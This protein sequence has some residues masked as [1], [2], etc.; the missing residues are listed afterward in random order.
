[1]SIAELF[2]AVQETGWA[3]A[4]RESNVVYPVILS[5]HLLAIA[6]FGGA[7]LLTNLRLLRLALRDTPVADVIRQLRPWK[8]AGF[9]ILVTCG[10]LLA[11][12]K[13]D[14]YYP[15][16]YFRVK[17]MLLAFVGVHAIAFRRSVYSRRSVPSPGRARLAALLSLAL[18]VG[19][20]SMGRWIAYYEPGKAGTA[21]AGVARSF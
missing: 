13:A 21:T 11:S 15:N 1:M 4:L 7:I 18:W 12:A 8:W 19:I 20:A 17:M 14:H 5:F 3:T 9:A 2:H 10:V 16:T 6:F